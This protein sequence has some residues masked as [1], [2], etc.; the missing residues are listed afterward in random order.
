M[1]ATNASKQPTVSDALFNSEM[2]VLA[3]MAR[4]MT[5]GEL[6]A[7]A[8]TT[9]GRISKIEHGLQEPPRDLVEKLSR[10]LAYPAEFFF[11]RGHIHGLPLRYHRKRRMIPRPTLDRIHAEVMIRTL[12]IERLLRAAEQQT[13]REIPE[14]DVDEYE[15]AVEHIA[16]AVR[17]QWQLPQGPVANLVEVLEG[18]G[19]IV[20]PCEFRVTEVDAIGIRLPNLPP[21]LFVNSAIPTDRLRFTLAHELGHLVMHRLP[22]PDMEEQANRFAAEFLM[23]A[24]DIRPQLYHL[25]LP[26]LATLK[27]VWRVA[28][29]ALLVRAKTL[30][31]ITHRQFVLLWQELGRLGY[32]RREP[33]ELDLEAERPALLAGLFKFYMNTLHYDAKE[34]CRVL[35]VVPALFN[36]W[37]GWIITGDRRP[38]QLV[39]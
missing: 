37:Y 15:G 7:A 26:A 10:A 25:S 17:E 23:P 21:L 14:I 20:V 24:D 9:Q 4:E 39:G 32:R 35:S 1:K 3:R 8:H 12:H 22:N 33:A 18:A 16:G 30:K 38:L 29:S 34:F 36:D 31:T 13:A 19:A 11:Q 5:Q 28:M 6:A 2:L 27:K